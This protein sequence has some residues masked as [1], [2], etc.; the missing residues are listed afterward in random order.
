MSKFTR[1]VLAALA[2]AYPW[3]GPVVAHA[4]DPT[5][6]M[7]GSADDNRT[8]SAGTGDLVR[9]L[10][11]GGH[12]RSG[13][14]AWDVPASADSG[15]LQRSAGRAPRAGTAEAIFTVVGPGRGTLVSARN[16]VPDPEADCPDP[17]PWQ[18]TVVAQ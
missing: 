11:V 8:I 5:L 17:V 4:D 6:I 10:L 12:D 9:V 13:T 3:F 1:T 14:W 16:C 2:V 18:V 7:L 15:V